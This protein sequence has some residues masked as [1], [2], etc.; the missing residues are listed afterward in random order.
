MPGATNR[1]SRRGAWS[2][3]SRRTMAAST[4]SSYMSK[5]EPWRYKGT[6]SNDTRTSTMSSSRLTTIETD[7]FRISCPAMMADAM[8]MTTST[9]PGLRCADTAI[10][11]TTWSRPKLIAMPNP[12]ASNSESVRRG[13]RSSVTRT[14]GMMPSATVALTTLRAAPDACSGS[15]PR[16]RRT[17]APTSTRKI[18][19]V[20]PENVLVGP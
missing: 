8:P 20:R 18:A 15:R 11:V 10:V 17:T 9:N 7:V 14:P 2:S 19:A 5:G 13:G 1:L 4:W 16:H 12:I 6:A 3:L